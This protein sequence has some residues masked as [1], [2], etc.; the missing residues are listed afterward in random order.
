MP[1]GRCLMSKSHKWQ[2]FKDDSE[3]EAFVSSELVATL[4]DD[5]DRMEHQERK[6]YTP[7]DRRE[8]R[9]KIADVKRYF[10]M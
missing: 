9:R 1:D 3:V 6:E 8:M 2:H 5:L 4:E 10:G 7:E